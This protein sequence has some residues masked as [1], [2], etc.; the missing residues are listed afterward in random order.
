MIITER[1]SGYNGR[2][3]FIS[4]LVR[5]NCNNESDLQKGCNFY[6][7]LVIIRSKKKYQDQ[8]RL[9]CFRECFGF[10]GI[11]LFLWLTC[12]CYGW[13]DAERGCDKK[14]LGERTV[15]TADKEILHLVLNY[16]FMIIH[17]AF[18][19]FLSLLYILQ[20]KKYSFSYIWW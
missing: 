12:V 16:T 4:F 15:W 5:L 9:A 8:Q 17:C 10:E 3:Q 2:K 6:K 11:L 14:I 20:N 19:C 7:Y 18:S 1:H 13:R